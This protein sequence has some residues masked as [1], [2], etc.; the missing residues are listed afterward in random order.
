VIVDASGGDV[1]LVVERVGGKN[2]GEGPGSTPLVKNPA[3][4][5][6]HRPSLVSG[7]APEA[8][9]PPLLLI[10]VAS[11]GSFRLGQPGAAQT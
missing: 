8:S 3:G 9:A 11:I 6:Q 5:G 1:G 2:K 10:V 7:I 4:A